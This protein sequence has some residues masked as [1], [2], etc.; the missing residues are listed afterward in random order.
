M[1][2]ESDAEGGIDIENDCIY[3]YLLFLQM[4]SYQIED[5]SICDS[6]MTRNLIWEI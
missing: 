1:Q 4:P 6:E 3:G 5:T 2:V